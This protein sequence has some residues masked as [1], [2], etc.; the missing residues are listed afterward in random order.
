[1]PASQ[2]SSAVRILLVEDE[3]L[4][5]LSLTHQ[6]EKL[7][8]CVIGHC[9]AGWDAIERAGALRPDLVIMDIHLEGELDGVEAAAEIRKQFDLPVIYLTAFSNPEVLDR[10]KHTEP[11]GYLLKPYE[12]RDL[13]VVIETGLYRHRAEQ[14]RAALR[15]AERASQARHA[16]LPPLEPSA[17]ARLSTL[18]PRESQVMQLLVAGNSLKQIAAKFEISFQTAAK[19]RAKVQEKLGVANDVELVRFVVDHQQ[20]GG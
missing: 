5:A 2:A 6:L 16:T 17:A 19:H 10:A 3:R 14:Q 18:S 1:M 12:E 4:V 9:S 8:H 20:N 11:L 7:G 15:E 13:H